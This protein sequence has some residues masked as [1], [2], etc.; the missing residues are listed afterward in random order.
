MPRCRKCH[1]Q[2]ATLF[3]CPH[4]ESRFPCPLHLLLVSLALPALIVAVIYL[5]S[6]FG[7]KLQDW[8]ATHKEEPREEPGLTVE[9][10]KSAVE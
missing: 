1:S 10:D 4:C 3:R 9:I 2:W 7:H 6:A 8:R 5:V